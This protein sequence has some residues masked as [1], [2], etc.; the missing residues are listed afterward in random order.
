MD[1][2][3]IIVAVITA[4]G[5]II[6][7]L[8]HSF[9]KENRED[10]ALVTEQFRLVHGTLKRIDDKVDSHLIW[11]SEGRHDSTTR[12]NTKRDTAKRRS[13]EQTRRDT[14]DTAI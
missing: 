14:G 4:I 7:A 9:R 8:L 1:S 10:H 6:A 13:A 11:H 2:T 12:R 3:A 5:G